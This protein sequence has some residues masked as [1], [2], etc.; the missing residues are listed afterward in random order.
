MIET[1]GPWPYSVSSRGAPLN[2]RSS[3]GSSD[4]IATIKGWRGGV[5]EIVTANTTRLFRLP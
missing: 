3:D 2:R 4:A 5:A 1:D